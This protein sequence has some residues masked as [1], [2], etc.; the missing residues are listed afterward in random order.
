MKEFIKKIIWGIFVLGI[1]C[2]MATNVN[3]D[4]IK[5]IEM[6]VYIDDD[7]NAKITE[8]W[9]ASLSQGTEGYRP[10]TNLGNSAISN[11][12][13]SD[14]TGRTYETLSSW[15]VN[16]SFN[17][18]A[19]KSGLHYISNGVELCWGI[20]SYGNRT[21]TLQYD[22]S[23]FVTQY[24]D[25]QGFY[26]NFLNLG[27]YVAKAK[28]TIR[29]DIPF[30][31]DNA[32]IWAFG[33]NGTINFVDG[34][35]VLDSGGALSSSQYM[36]GLVRFET[37]LFKTTNSSGESFDEV[38]ASAM[39]NVDKDELEDNQDDTNG[40][41]WTEGKKESIE[42]I[43]VD[44][45]IDETGNAKITEVWKTYLKHGTEGYK[46]YTKLGNSAISNFIVSDDTGR[47]YE[48]LTSWDSSASFSSKA[49]KSGIRYKDDGIELCWGIS[50]Y[51]NMTYTLQYD[52]SNFVTQY[53]D[54]QGFYFNFL[55]LGQYVAK[56]KVTIHS[57]I[58]FSLDNAR[59]WAFGNNGT[60]N[61]VD[62]NI[63][64]DSGGA[65]SSS[66]YMVGLVRFETDLFKTTNLSDESFNDVYTSAMSDVNKKELDGEDNNSKSVLQKF[67]AEFYEFLE[68]QRRIIINVCLSPVVLV[69]L[70][71]FLF[72]I[73][74]KSF[75]RWLFGSGTHSGDLDFGTT[76]RT[77]PKNSEIEYWRDIPCDKDLEEAYWVAYEYEVIP[78]DTLKKG[79]V[80][81]ILLK[82]IKE[83]KITVSKLPKRFF[84][85]KDNNYAIDFNNF[86]KADNTIENELLGILKS[87]AG[88]NGILEPKEFAKWCKKNYTRVDRWFSRFIRNEQ[89][90]LEKKKLIEPKEETVAASFGRTKSITLKAVSP[91]LLDEAIHLKGLKKFLLD[92]SIM[93]EREYFEV[94]IWEE[95]LIFAQLLGIADKVEKQFKKL[96]PDFNEIAKI[97]TDVTMVAVRNMVDKGYKGFDS[98]KYK[99]DFWSSDYSGSSRSSGG[100]GSSYHSGGSSAGGS[101][102]G[103][104]R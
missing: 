75:L 57:D 40:S 41:S 22:I 92:F 87:A 47:T 31:L 83:D 70:I 72:I 54:V 67:L 100:G 58:P 94:E 90:E 38:Y 52:V 30:S 102:G 78:E 33:N 81:A 16:A 60:I 35:I 3:A 55:N 66:Q 32:R 14:D 6:D 88:K 85:F 7:G 76:G 18:K 103:G 82:W 80:G 48:S 91:T 71:Y 98:G 101:S 24:Q 23:N 44:V 27:Q 86:T 53:Q 62:G 15:N 59:I 45:Y 2:L 43:K 68:E 99:T 73:I 95:Y 25:T 1:F 26:F 77:L 21:Y 84:S 12:R 13:V 96:Y 20:S 97:K 11:F 63:V 9:E 5:N 79:I 69:V 104:F 64:L 37:N 8:V 36:V 74:N 29:S 61:F 46:L 93:P 28:V 51:G 17:N 39:G 19:Y 89:E 65:L 50:S 4:S 42:S 56:A 10:Y 34:N 49:Y